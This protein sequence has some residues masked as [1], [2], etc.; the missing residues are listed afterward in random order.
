VP[1]EDRQARNGL[2]EHY[3]PYQSKFSQLI[4]FILVLGNLRGIQQKSHLQ[5]CWTG[6]RTSNKGYST[7]GQIIVNGY[8]VYALV[9]KF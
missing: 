4:N 6:F 5:M 8:Y 3:M 9:E 2:K 7:L 1:R